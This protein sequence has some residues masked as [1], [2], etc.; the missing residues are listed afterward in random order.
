MKTT[1]GTMKIQL[2]PRYAPVTV[3]NFVFLAGYHY[4]DGIVFHRVIPGFMNQGGDPT[5]TGTGGPGYEF[6]DELPKS[7]AAYDAGALAMANSGPNTNGS[8]FFI[9]VG[10]GGQQ[11]QPSYTM[12]GQVVSGMSVDDKINAGGNPNP[13]ANGVPP[14]TLYKIL[15]VSISATPVSS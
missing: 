1:A 6:K 14:K 15:S 3:N 9:T 4:F 13:S 7:A 2:L 11:L 10:K 12:F 8:Q 5:G